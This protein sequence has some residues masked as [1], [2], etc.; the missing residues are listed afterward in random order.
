[1]SRRAYRVAD[2]IGLLLVGLFLILWGLVTL[3]ALPIPS[4]IL[5]IVA[6]A[7]GLL[8]IIGR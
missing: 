4:V 2:N 7:A 1:M 8:V 3:L 6:L 5:A